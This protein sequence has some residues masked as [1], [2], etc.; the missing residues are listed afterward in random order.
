MHNATAPNHRPF[1][2]SMQV[3]L[4]LVLLIKLAGFF[5]W[6]DS[7]AFTQVFKTI[8]RVGMTMATYALY[9]RVLHRGAVASFQWQ[10]SLAPL[11]YSAY[12]LLGAASVM[13]STAPGYSLL[14]LLMDV[15]SFVFAYYFVKCF[16]LL[17]TYFPGSSLRLHRV[18]A[19]T[20]WI[21]IVGFLV[22]MVVAP[23]V[24]YRLT[25]GGEEA[26]LGGFLMNPNELGMLCGVCVACLL[27]ELLNR[28]RP[29]L[30]VLK[31]LPVVYAL[32]LTGSRSSLIGL[33]LVALFYLWNS[34]NARLRLA[35]MAA[36]LLAVPVV[37][38]TVF[39]KQGGVSEVMSLT[40]RLPFWEALLTEG[41]PKEPLLG[42]GFMRIAYT[43]YFQ[44]THTY[45]AQMT[46]NT[47]IQV[48]MNLGLVGFGLVL[49]QLWFTLRGFATT[50]ERTQR[51]LFIGLFI[52]LLINS[53]T[54]FGIFGQTNYGIL[55]YQFLILLVS[56]RVSPRLTVPER[57]FLSD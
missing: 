27:P 43:D 16:L 41:L 34:G 57:L 52:P 28:Q 37:V 19:T 6:S 7:V 14:Q 50:P 38:Q 31:M 48:L 3:L 8:S 1:L 13:W 29:V 24:F 25:H 2:R 32:V 47:F 23:D 26:R 5:T 44:S 18:L 20:S 33:L 22:G 21:L 39:I 17:G 45:A 46:H 4:T 36:V 30:A 15:E 12:L 42:F 9:R 51:L 55:F 54:E 53:V 10:N 40:G 11:F 35:G 56:L 49:A